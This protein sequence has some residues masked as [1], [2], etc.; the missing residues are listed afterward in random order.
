MNRRVS[1]PVAVAISVLAFTVACSSPVNQLTAPTGVTEVTTAALHT[2]VPCD[3]DTVAPVIS[4]ASATPNTLWS[5]NHKWW[6]IQVNY[7]ASDNCGTPRTFLTVASDEPVNGLGDGN[8]SPDWQV[9]SAS[10]VRLRAERSGTG[11]GRVYTITI[12]AVDQAGNTTTRA[13]TVTVKHD[14]RKK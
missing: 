11:D 13:V 5:P 2:P 4:N 1:T 8:T 10:S 3:H 14:Q 7:N 6:T 9:V 12:H